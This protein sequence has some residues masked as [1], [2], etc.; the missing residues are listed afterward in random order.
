M[1]AHAVNFFRNIRVKVRLNNMN[2]FRCRN[3]ATRSLAEKDFGPLVPSESCCFLEKIDRAGG[4][5]FQR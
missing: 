5:K 2:S 4:K 3:G 1:E